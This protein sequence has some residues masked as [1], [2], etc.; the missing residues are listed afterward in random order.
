MPRGSLVMALGLILSVAAG[1]VSATAQQAPGSNKPKHIAPG[2]MAPLPPA[3]IDDEL[4]IGGD[5]IDARK[6]SSRMTVEVMVNRTGPYHFLVDSGADTSVVGVKIAR[7]LQLKAGAPLGE[8]R[9][10][11]SR[12]CEDFGEPYF[13][14][15]F[16]FAEP[17]GEQTA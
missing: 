16:D 7:A 9:T 4:A 2:S 5:D 15:R 10:F 13:A 8:K 17:C 14:L 1:D 6:V 3:V 12:L 11:A